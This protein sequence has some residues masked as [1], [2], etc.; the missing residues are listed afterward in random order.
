LGL[1][2]NKNISKCVADPNRKNQVKDSQKYI[3][4]LLDFM[5]LTIDKEIEYVIAF[6]FKGSKF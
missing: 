3:S 6:R 1:C 2:Y 4:K 5:D